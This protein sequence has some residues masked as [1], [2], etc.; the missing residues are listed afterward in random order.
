MPGHLDIVGLTRAVDREG[1]EK[2]ARL[3]RLNRAVRG[4][5]QVRDD[6]EILRDLIQE[7]S[8]RNSEADPRGGRI[9]SIEAVFQQMS[10]S[11]PH[12]S[13]L[14]LS[15]IGDLG[16]QILNAETTQPPVSTAAT[17]ETKILES[18]KTRR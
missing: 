3:Q 6:W 11:I 16:L 10:E 4:P 14:S 9:D 17:E 15:K 5:G 13:G 18:D 2:P 1:G 8:G 7:C 12:F